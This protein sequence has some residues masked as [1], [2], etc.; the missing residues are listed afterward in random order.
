M[1]NFAV[2]GACEVNHT[3]PYYQMVFK[4]SSFLIKKLDI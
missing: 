2:L 3:K 1:I 4:M